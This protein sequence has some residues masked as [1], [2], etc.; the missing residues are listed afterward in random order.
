MKAMIQGPV[1][2]SSHSAVRGATRV[3]VEIAGNKVL[4]I[5]GRRQ[6]VWD[7]WFAYD[8]A[9]FD[10]DEDRR[11]AFRAAV[12]RMY[13]SIWYWVFLVAGLVSVLN[14]KVIAMSLFEFPLGTVGVIFG[15]MAVVTVLYGGIWLWRRAIRRSLRQQLLARGIPVCLRCGYC[16][17]GAPSTRCP[18]CGSLFR[19]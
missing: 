16:L 7:K 3:R 11:N 13:H 10:T 4:R 14:V 18:E 15:G 9:H 1:F 6:S 2:W 8:L 5:D 17:R 19:K 12:N